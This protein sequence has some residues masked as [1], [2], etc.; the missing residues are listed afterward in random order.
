MLEVWYYV[1][2]LQEQMLQYSCDIYMSL[3]YIHVN[4]L[5]E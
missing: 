1:P 3:R 5:L 2:K 4:V